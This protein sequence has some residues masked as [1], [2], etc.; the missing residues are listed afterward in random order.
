[1]DR[2]ADERQLGEA[3]AGLV[4]DLRPLT[5]AGAAGARALAALER[6]L[7]RPEAQRPAALAPAFETFL[8][9]CAE[10]APDADATADDLRAFVRTHHAGLLA[11]PQFAELVEHPRRHAQMLAW[12]LHE[13]VEGLERA[14][15]DLRLREHEIAELRAELERIDAEKL[16]VETDLQRSRVLA[17]R[18]LAAAGLAHDFANLLQSILGHTALVRDRLPANAPDRQAL[19]Q[20]ERAA[21]RAAELSRGLARWDRDPTPR[22]RA[23]DLNAIVREVLDLLAASSPHQV[24]EQ[25]LLAEALPHVEADPTDVRRIVLN[26]VMNA[27]QALGARAGT[28]R[29]STGSVAAPGDARVYLE[30]EDDGPGMDDDVRARVFEPFFSTRSGGGGIG[31]PNVRLLAERWDGRIEAWSTRGAGTR[32]RVSFPARPEAGDEAGP[33]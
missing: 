30:V 16:A 6:L 29:V 14:R 25:R 22:A 28:V 18:G 27:W 31:L 1:M 8:R 7:D 23:L 10:A 12:L 24:E 2:A 17:D 21:Q 9:A 4:A 19:E 26:L 20:V 33:A 13:N 32:F 5:P 11:I 15:G 3:I